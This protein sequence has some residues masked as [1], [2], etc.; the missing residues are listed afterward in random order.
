MSTI[1]RLRR[2]REWAAMEVAHR[3]PKKIKYWVMI[4]GLV[5][6]TMAFNDSSPGEITV[7]DVLKNMDHG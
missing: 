7:E 3:L 5:K 2:T 6:A 1:E 4:N